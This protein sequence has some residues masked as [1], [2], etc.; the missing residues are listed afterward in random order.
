[1]AGGVE[2]L[3]FGLEIAVD[4]C[5]LSS[6]LGILLPSIP[7]LL[8]RVAATRAMMLEKEAWFYDRL[9]ILQGSIVPR[10]YSLFEAPMKWSKIKTLVPP[11]MN[12]V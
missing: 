12:A 5:I 11:M 7:P 8:V 6:S 2:C 4:G 3:E 10:C 9:Q 1:M